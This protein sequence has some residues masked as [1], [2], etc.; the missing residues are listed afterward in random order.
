M[1]HQAT[2]SRTSRGAMRIGPED[3]GRAFSLAEWSRSIETPGYIYEIIDGA[4]VVSPNPAPSHDY[5]VQIVEEELR[6]YAAENPKSINWITERCDVVVPGRAGE[7]RPQPDLAAFRNY[8][9]QPPKSWDEVCPI[10]VVEVI[11]ARRGAKDITRNRHLY[12]LAGGIREYWVIDPSKSQR[13]P[14]LIAHVRGRGSKEWRR[15]IVPFDKNYESP[16]LGGFALNLQQA[17]KR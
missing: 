7:T 2:T 6:A 1:G 14:T 12:W 4:L 10:V 8:P 17:S 9:R 5:W 3:H 11:S 13:R 16:T 15:S